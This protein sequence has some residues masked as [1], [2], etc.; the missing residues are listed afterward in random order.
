MS[1]TP[2]FNQTAKTLK[3]LA[4]PTR[5]QILATLQADG[6]HSSGALAYVLELEPSTVSKHLAVLQ[7]A[8]LVTQ[9][10]RGPHHFYRLTPAQL[11]LSALLQT[12]HSWA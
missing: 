2:N 9:Y 10:A 11:R 8:G 1:Q 4:H 3:A 12:I 7:T 5:L 6:E